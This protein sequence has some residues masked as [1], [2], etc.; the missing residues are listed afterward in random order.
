MKY[1]DV[2][3]RCSTMGRIV[4]RSELSPTSFLAALSTETPRALAML[5]PVECDHD[6]AVTAGQGR[7]G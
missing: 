4:T 3:P 7:T 5:L 1:V 2:A 6:T